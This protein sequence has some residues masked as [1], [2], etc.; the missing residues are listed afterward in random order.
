PIAV[1]IEVVDTRNLGRHVLHATRLLAEAARPVVVPAIPRV[2]GGGGDALQLRGFRPC[3]DDLLSAPDL[4]LAI[5]AR[6]NHARHPTPARREAGRLVL[7][8]ETVVSDVG[9]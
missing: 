5:A 2:I 8:V 3:H 4:D 1:A 7:D 9:G 6:R